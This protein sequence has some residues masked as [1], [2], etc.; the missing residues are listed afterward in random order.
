MFIP[1]FRVEPHRR[2]S[3][4]V[5]MSTLWLPP[6][7]LTPFH[8][9]SFYSL[10]Y[11]S[12]STNKPRSQYTKHRTADSPPLSRPPPYCSRM[13]CHRSQPSTI[14]LSRRTPKPF[15]HRH[16]IAASQSSIFFKNFSSPGFPHLRKNTQKGRHRNHK[17]LN[18]VTFF[19]VLSF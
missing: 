6:P 16:K 12:A 15:P 7:E 2:S 9:R 17:H 10:K 5:H 18:S 11:L 4:T 13:A 1:D 3:H 19:L 8:F 14:F